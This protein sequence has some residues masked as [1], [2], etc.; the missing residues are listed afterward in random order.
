MAIVQRFLNGKE[1]M[2]EIERVRNLE[3][4]LATSREIAAECLKEKRIELG[5][6]FRQV[7]AGVRV[8]PATVYNIEANKSWRTRTAAKIARFY[9]RI[10]A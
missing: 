2:R 1:N 6:S 5:L 3:S 8:S 10:A 7:S 4:E 9:E